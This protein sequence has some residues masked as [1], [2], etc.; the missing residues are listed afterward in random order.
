M[1]QHQQHQLS[2][3]GKVPSA[4]VSTGPAA[5]FQM[6]AAPGGGSSEVAGTDLQ[7]TPVSR[8]LFS[9]VNMKALQDAIRH[10]VFQ[11]TGQVIGKQSET[12]LGVI[13]RS[14]YLQY[15][16]NSDR[17]GVVSQVKDLNARVI[18]FAVP[19]IAGE[20]H[21]YLCYRRDISAPRLIMPHAEAVSVKGTKTAE[22]RRFF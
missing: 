15:G 2:A 20:V 5:P 1:F 22:L 8:L 18:G 10:G 14:V 21:A 4:A 9:D 7:D 13:L 6:F 19:R 12:E 17:R 11:R 3:A 16:L